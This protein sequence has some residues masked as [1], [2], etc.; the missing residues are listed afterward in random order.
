MSDKEEHMKSQEE[1]VQKIDFLE[2]E[3]AR[4][5]GAYK[6]YSA[7]VE[8]SNWFYQKHMEGAHSGEPDKPEH[9]HLRN[10]SKDQG[11][12]GCFL[13]S[14]CVEFKGLNDDCYELSTLRGFRDYYISQ[15]NDGEENIKDYY[16]HAPIIV[17]NIDKS[18]TRNQIYADMYD[19]LII[20][21]IKLIEENE[22]NS[23]Y[24]V[25]SNYYS[26]LKESYA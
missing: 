21:C 1:I 3:F 8:D 22:L 6:G 18:E 2:P 9:E 13:T 11:N 7:H 23:A 24:E 12:N 5:D 15:L 4:K 20:K 19:N 26:N 25:Y 16:E 10:K 17:E 14:A